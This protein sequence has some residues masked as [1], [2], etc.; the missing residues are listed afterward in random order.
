MRL[1]IVPM[2]YALFATL[3][4]IGWQIQ[5]SSWLRT[6]KTDEPIVI[7]LITIIGIGYVILTSLVAQT[8]WAEWKGIQMA[9][10]ARDEVKFLEYKG[11][12]LSPQVKLLL[13]M[14]S[15]LLLVPTMILL[16]PTSLVVAAV[17]VFAVTFMITAFWVVSNDL[18]DYWT[19]VWIID[20]GSVPEEWRRKHFNS[21]EQQKLFGEK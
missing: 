16:A 12:R 14:F 9:I 13:G 10:S 6:L 4:E 15:A 19:S 5:M 7:V 3:L 18:D 8:V 20:L 21:E 11:Q 2:A 1:L 17:L